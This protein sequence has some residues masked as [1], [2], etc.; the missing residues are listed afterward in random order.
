MNNVKNEILYIKLINICYVFNM[1]VFVLGVGDKIKVK[2]WRYSYEVYMR[3][4]TLII[5]NVKVWLC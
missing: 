5:E 3:K 1:L 2:K 4:R